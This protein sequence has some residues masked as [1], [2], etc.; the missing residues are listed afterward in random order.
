MPDSGK[1]VFFFFKKKHLTNI[2]LCKCKI[3]SL[4]ILLLRNM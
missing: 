2:L 4:S 1:H 3:F